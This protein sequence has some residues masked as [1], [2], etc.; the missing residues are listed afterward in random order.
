MSNQTSYMCDLHSALKTI[1]DCCFKHSDC[2]DP[3]PLYDSL[4]ERCRINSF[5]TKWG[6]R[7]TPE[8]IKVIKIFEEE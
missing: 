1:Q 7:E 6:L 8:I 3:C 5:P 4:H 2:D